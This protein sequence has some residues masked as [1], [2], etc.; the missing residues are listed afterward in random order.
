MEEFLVFW[1]QRWERRERGET[2]GGYGVAMV[3][4]RIADGS[5]YPTVAKVTCDA[6]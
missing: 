2:S 6:A 4:G 3:G 1:D 5:T